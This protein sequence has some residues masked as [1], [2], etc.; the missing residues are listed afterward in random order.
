MLSTPVIHAPLLG[1]LAAAGHGSTIL[2]A[3]ANYPVSTA[4]LPQAPVIHLNLQP[5]LIDAFTI[6]AALRR[7][8][9][10]EAAAVMAP[11]GP[12]PVILAEFDRALAGVPVT[13]L[14]RF[15]FYA[16][17]RGDNLAVV[18]ATGELRHYGNLLLTV[19]VVPTEEES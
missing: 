14:S 7:I 19:G 4:A 9:P 3:D 10:I 11:E 16:A 18:I 2:V 13:R 15:G 8:M 17:A 12:E 1:A 5:G 6:L